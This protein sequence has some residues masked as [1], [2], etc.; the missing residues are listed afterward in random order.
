MHATSPCL[1]RSDKV[2]LTWLCGYCV[3]SEISFG[4]S[5]LSFS[6]VNA[7]VLYLLAL[8]VDENVQFRTLLAGLAL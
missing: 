1:L 2:L 4:H 6:A 5:T 8:T 7:F 3:L